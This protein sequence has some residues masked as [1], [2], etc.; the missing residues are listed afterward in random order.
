MPISS[1]TSSSLP[2]STSVNFDHH[3]KGD[4]GCQFSQWF[5]SFKMQVP[6]VGF[7]IIE[8]RKANGPYFGAFV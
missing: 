8:L 3:I 4:S 5:W 7:M 1:Q 6:I 2:P